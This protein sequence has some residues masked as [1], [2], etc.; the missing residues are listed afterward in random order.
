MPRR[1]RRALLATWLG[2]GVFLGGL[3]GP[4]HAQQQIPLEPKQLLQMVVARNAEVLFNKLQSDIASFGVDAQAALYEPVLYATLRNEGRDRQRTVEERLTTPL[5]NVNRL[6]EQVQLYE[7][8]LRMRAPTGA[9]FTTSVRIVNRDNN[10]I[11]SARPNRDGQE[12]AGALVVTMRQPLL[13]GAGRAVVET[14]LRVAE[15]DRE[16][17][18]WQYKQQILRVGGEALAAYWQ[19]LRAKA[20][21]DVRLAAVNNGKELFRD[22]K[23]RAD[24]GRLP[25]NSL[26]EA[27]SAMLA[28]DA[29]LLRADATVADAESR[30]RTLLNL[31][32]F[33]SEFSIP[34]LS[35]VSLGAA[36]AVPAKERYER[37]LAIWPSYR[38]ALL[39]REQNRH[40]L[41][42]ADNQRKAQ[43]DL[44]VSYSSNSLVMG[45]REA[46]NELLP[47]KNPDWYIGL[48]YERPIGRNAGANARYSAQAVR[49]QQSDLEV[50]SVQHA[51]GNDI[52]SRTSQF[53]AAL[54]DLKGMEDDLKLRRDLL[55]GE[56]E[57]YRVG[58]SP[59]SQIL[60]R[61]GDVIETE[62]RVVDAQMRLELA[63]TALM[64]ADGSLLTDNQIEVGY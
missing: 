38:I 37:A 3:A 24:G 17:S 1:K 30:I 28:R 9:E 47:K 29:E 54:T 4:A 18:V 5:S 23:A 55:E 8:G 48:S 62:L 27:Q 61:E 26:L 40:R 11:A 63:R 10:L 6:D 12:T 21:R 36:G 57:M 56:R 22:V 46:F 15:L 19:L 20:L 7:T 52:Q 64:T 32:P 49:L 2:A 39:K 58:L 16:A 41:E 44:L 33:E 60:R 35:Q 43:L 42:F 34:A 45:R 31:P 14:D 13:R 59:L 50:Q 25:P 51:L 53:D